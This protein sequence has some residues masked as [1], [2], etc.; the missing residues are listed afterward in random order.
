MFLYASRWFEAI[1]LPI[2]NLCSELYPTVVIIFYIVFKDAQ[3]YHVIEYSH[4]NWYN[5]NSLVIRDVTDLVIGFGQS[6][7][8][9]PGKGI[10][11]NNIMVIVQ[12]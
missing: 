8:I 7:S 4:L 10:H 3:M 2:S 12:P 5:Q 6:N 9:I 11:A 1:A